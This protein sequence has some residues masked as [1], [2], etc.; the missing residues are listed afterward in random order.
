MAK[1][2]KINS[3]DEAVVADVP[4]NKKSSAPRSTKSNGSQEESS[5]MTAVIIA[6]VAILIIGGSIGAFLLFVKIKKSYVEPFLKSQ[7]GTAVP[8]AVLPQGE[9]GLGDGTLISTGTSPVGIG[10]TVPMTPDTPVP[11]VI[12]PT[13][14]PPIP[15]APDVPEVPE[16]EKVGS[17]DFDG[18]IAE[19][20]GSMNGTYDT[21]FNNAFYSNDYF[22][23]D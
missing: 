20:D 19:M 12:P 13:P 14:E 11:P 5:S 23:F 8:I 21:T 17:Y 7:A 3:E 9:G 2:K 16:P 15:P 4:N 22:G 6:L 1:T 18:T 10:E